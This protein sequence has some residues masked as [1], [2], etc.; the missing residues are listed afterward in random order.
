MHKTIMYIIIGLVIV[1]MLTHPA[2]TAVAMTGGKDLV[3][4]ESAILA[5]QGQT[6]GTHGTVISGPST[7]LL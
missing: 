6:G 5:G 2:G 7:F 1:A 3:T 4:G